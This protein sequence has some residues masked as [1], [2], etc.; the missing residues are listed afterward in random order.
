[1]VMRWPAMIALFAALWVAANALFALLYLAGGDCIRGAEPL[2]F[3]A[4]F[5]FSVQSMSTVGYGSMSPATPWAD[6][7][8]T[9]ETFVGLLA[10]AVM[11]G[12]V[13]AKFARPTARV[14]FSRHAV[15]DPGLDDDHPTLTF[16]LANER[17]NQIV[18]ATVDIVMVR[19]ELQP[20]GSSMRRMHTLA[21]ERSRSPLFALSWTVMHTLDESSPLH[22]TTIEQM[23]ETSVELV[24]SLTGIDGTLS[25]N[26]YARHSYVADDIVDQA[27]LVDIFRRDEDGK[28]MIDFEH[29][30]DIEDAD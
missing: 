3:F 25:Q 4:A 23:R 7:L 11:T 12:L 6:I 17:S 24:I 15:L 29:F 28:M 2:T 18:D 30:H 8:V 1:M 27:R 16:R 22:D 13:F 10:T 26:I 5:S 21:L 9:V 19:T 14:M 20:D